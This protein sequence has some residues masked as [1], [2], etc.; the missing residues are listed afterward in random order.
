MLQQ[1]ISK[2]VSLKET[3]K[4]ADHLKHKAK[5]VKAFLK[6]KDEKDW[7]SLRVRFPQ[8]ATEEKMAQFNG[9]ALKIGVVPPL[10]TK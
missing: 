5:V 3:R 9:V 10:T 8:Q 2:Q 7:E 1:V 6:F 4:S